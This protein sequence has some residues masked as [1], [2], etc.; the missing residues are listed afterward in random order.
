MST[1][2]RDLRSSAPV[3]RV[4]RL[5]TVHA[6]DVDLLRKD[7]IVSRQSIEVRDARA[8][9]VDGDGRII[10]VEGTEI[11][12]DRAEALLKDHAAVLKAADAESV[13]R[14]FRSQ[15]ED[16]AVGMGLVFGP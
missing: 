14:R 15:D 2:K 13:Y 4:F 9:G 8:L 10:L 16:A 1:F 5:A 3:Y 11:A 12:L 7:D 6:G